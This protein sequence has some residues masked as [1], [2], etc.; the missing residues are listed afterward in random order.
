MGQKSLLT[1]QTIEKQQNVLFPLKQNFMGG[2]KQT[3]SKS[4]LI[5][6]FPVVSGATTSGQTTIFRGALWQLLSGP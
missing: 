3:K 2:E 1:L 5:V 6:L 4:D